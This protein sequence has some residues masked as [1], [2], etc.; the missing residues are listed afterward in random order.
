[1]NKDRNIEPLENI[2]VSLEI[3][4]T[5]EIKHPFVMVLSSLVHVFSTIGICF[6]PCVIKP[7]NKLFEINDFIEKSLATVIFEFLITF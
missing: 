4:Q 1:M 6:R 5:F 2:F 3:I 7:M